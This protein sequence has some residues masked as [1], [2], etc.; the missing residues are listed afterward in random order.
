MRSGARQC[1]MCTE[2][3]Y[4]CV[5]KLIRSWPTTTL[6]VRLPMIPR[7]LQ[8]S[9]DSKDAAWPLC[10]RAASP[11]RADGQNCQCSSTRLGGTVTAKALVD[12]C[13]LSMLH[14]AVS[15]CAGGLH[16]EDG[17]EAWWYTAQAG[18]AGSEP[19]GHTVDLTGRPDSPRSASIRDW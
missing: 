18:K 3:S 11:R 17:G 13:R 10:S 19:S 1:K 12:S 5:R 2:T 7:S 6:P 9:R 16:Q 8:T 4:L 15:V 14:L